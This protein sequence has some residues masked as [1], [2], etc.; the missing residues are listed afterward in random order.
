MTVGYGRTSSAE[1]IADLAG[2]ER[3]LTAAGAERVFVEQV[4]S[5]A[6][7]SVLAGRLAFL[8]RGGVLMVTK[9]DRHRYALCR[10]TS[11]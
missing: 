1:P 6:E 11:G 10:I 2:Q 9:P 8:R 5:M 3:D 7:Q 4:S